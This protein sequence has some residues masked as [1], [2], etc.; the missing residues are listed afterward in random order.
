MPML[1]EAVSFA[2][3]PALHRTE[4]RA[5]RSGIVMRARGGPPQ[6]KGQGS[7]YKTN[8]DIRSTEVRVIAEMSDEDKSMVEVN[9]VMDTRDALQ[10][11]KS[12]GL[13]L[14]LVNE[15]RDPPLVK[16]V[17]VGKY[18]YDEKKREKERSRQGKQPKTKDVKMSYTIGDH[19]LNTKLNMIKK[20]LDNKR[21][22]VRVTIQ[23]KGRTRMFEKQARELLNRVINNAAAYGKPAGSVKTADPIVKDRKGDL[24]V[25]FNSGA[26]I[27][28]LKQLRD[29]GA[30]DIADDEDEEEEDDDDDDDDDND[31]AGGD[32][33]LSSELASIK[34]EMEEMKQEL[35]D[36]GI[37][38][39]QLSQQPEML[40]LVQRL[41]QVK[42]KI[43]AKVASSAFGTLG[44]GR[45]Q[46]LGAATLALGVTSLA[47]LLR[48]RRS[49]RAGLL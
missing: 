8:E 9:L 31:E 2:R 29:E 11:A 22:Q 37:N 18:T 26:N 42:A 10:K 5:L 13:D 21:Q 38:P 27:Q 46:G 24:Y 25:M 23:M 43:D 41:N 33:E 15:D 7:T 45:P 49:R 17:D 30:F 39:G 34:E 40:E 28:L 4:G 12:R 3:T 20:W 44:R 35:L 14:V 1:L 16:I 32:P 47:T 19:D 6:P 48:P 36:C